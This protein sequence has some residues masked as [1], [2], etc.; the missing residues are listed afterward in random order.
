MINNFFFMLPYNN[1]SHYYQHMRFDEIRFLSIS[2]I[3]MMSVRVFVSK[4]LANC[5]IDMVF[6]YSDAACRS[7]E[8]FLPFLGRP[9]EALVFFSFKKNFLS[10]YLSVH[11][12]EFWFGG[13]E[14]VWEYVQN[15]LRG[16]VEGFWQDINLPPIR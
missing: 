13:R 10:E 4:N 1:I 11:L 7:K 16:W 3:N 9:L 14:G 12:I 2:K 8:V 6:L 5:W 15:L